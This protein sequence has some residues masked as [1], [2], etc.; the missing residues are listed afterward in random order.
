MN[1]EPSIPST[2]K[3]DRYGRILRLISELRET[4]DNE[5]A[6]CRSKSMVLTK[7]DEAR[8]WTKETPIGDTHPQ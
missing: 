8:L 6:S 7:L 2:L 4:V 1:Q 5:M 3:E